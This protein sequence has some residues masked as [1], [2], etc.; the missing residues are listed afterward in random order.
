MA[1]QVYVLG[2]LENENREV[3][4]V[5]NGESTDLPAGAQFAYNSAFT[6]FPYTEF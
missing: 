4:F 6:Q 5:P 3:V 1:D 2:S